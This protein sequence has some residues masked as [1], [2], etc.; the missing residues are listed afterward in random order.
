[1]RPFDDRRILL[2]VSGGIAAYKSA[3]LAR[4]LLRAGAD[5]DVVLTRSARRFVGRATFEGLTG[6]P[7]HADMWERP[8]AHLDLGREADAAVVAPAT[9]DLLA[10][11][12]AGRADDLAAA[13][14]LAFAGPVLA[15]PAMNVR[16]WRHPATRRS[17]SRLRQ[18]GVELVGPEHGELAEREV[19]PGR[20]S[21]PE[22]I[23]AEVA[24]ALERGRGS[25]LEGRRVVVTAGP[26]RSPLD[27]VRFLTNGSSGRMGYALAASAWRRGADTTLITGP[28][29]AEPPHGP[30]VVAVER[31]EEML[32]ALRE[33]LP[34][35][36]VLLM[37]AAVADYRP[38]GERSEKIGKENGDLEIRLQPGPDLLTETLED[39]RS[40]GVF[41]L[42]FALETGD[43]RE[44]A[45]RKME[46]KGMNLV[47]LNE[48]G[49][50]DVGIGAV[51]NQVTLLG[52]GGDEEE[53]PRLTKTETADRILDRIE[54]L[55][56]E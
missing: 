4:L 46:E 11:M 44:R 45:L 36:D 38:E 29:R 13:T 12:A 49:R 15:C 10:R 1:M 25:P 22:T 18:D 35:A 37:A 32:E 8:M 5:V 56:D 52:G 53:L 19:G 43:G 47:A 26:T 23:H 30:R 34:T 42:G 28:G 9:A 40:R 55:L 48:A 21:E 6:R 17:V 27:P 33:E 41:T 51:D 16:M 54:E 2:V 7:V 31:S 50:P 39:R 24:R 14:L 3:H 20:M